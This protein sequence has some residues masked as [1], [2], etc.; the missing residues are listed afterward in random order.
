MAWSNLITINFNKSD[1]N[2]FSFSS[3]MLRKG[4]GVAT[5]TWQETASPGT[6]AARASDRRRESLR[7]GHGLHPLPCR[8]LWTGLWLVNTKNTR[9]WLVRRLWTGP[10]WAEAKDPGSRS[11]VIRPLIGQYKKYSPLIGQI[12]YCIYSTTFL[13]L[14]GQHNWYSPLIGQCKKYSPLIGQHKKFSPLIGQHETYSTL[15]GQVWHYVIPLS[16][17]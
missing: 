13:F 10:V 3:V 7:P 14:I 2:N 17:W 6:L 15:I 5:P 1:L 12:W 9:L 8:R 4:P 11:Q 16:H